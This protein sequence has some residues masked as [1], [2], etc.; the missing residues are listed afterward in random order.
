MAK[1]KLF[2]LLIYGISLID[3]ATRGPAGAK[4]E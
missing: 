3:E 2:L 1:P 4:I